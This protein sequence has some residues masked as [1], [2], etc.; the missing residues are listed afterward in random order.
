LSNKKLLS[1][2]I[3]G[4]GKMGML[5]ASIVNTLP[6]ARAI[7]IYDKST[8]MQR[9]L[10]KAL[11]DIKIVNTFEKFAEQK[12][13]AVYVTTPIPSH[14]T[15]INELLS[16]GIAKH[17][18]VE[19]TLTA[20]YEQSEMIC[21]KAEGAWGVTMVGYM[22]RFAPTFKKAK[23]L[24]QEE[25][26]GNP[27][28][29]KAYAYA[30]DFASAKNRSLQDKGGATRDLGAHV[31][32]LSLWFFGDLTVAPAKLES[33]ATVDSDDGSR[34]QV[35]GSSGLSGEFD[36]SWAKE[37]YRLPEFGFEIIG[38]GG[39]IKVNAD[40][41]KLEKKAGKIAVWHR[42]DFDDNVPFLLG[43]P[44]YFRENEHF[45]RAILNGQAAEPD[46]AAASRVDRLI[47]QAE[48]SGGYGDA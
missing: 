5:H 29:F 34:F 17:I 24:L 14:Y 18:F 11:P 46:F 48:K 13:D 33:T 15:I 39:N 16:H 2:G 8:L 25:M 37:G 9:F 6:D 1:I 22:S 10:G 21:K 26:I 4:M 19:K 47:E 45:I 36:I 20:R 42:Q 7:A 28:L 43:A 12:Y 30:S 41:V 35:T 44:E 32:D 31:I 40:V 23:V 38:D 27:L 3:I